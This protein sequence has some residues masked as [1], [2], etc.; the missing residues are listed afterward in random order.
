MGG[1]FRSNNEMWLP[2]YGICNI[3]SINNGKILKYHNSWDWIIPVINKIYLSD[4]YF[5]YKES[6]SIFF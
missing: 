1:T 2:I 6:L 3:G 5:E 4:E